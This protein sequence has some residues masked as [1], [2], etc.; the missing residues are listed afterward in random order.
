MSKIKIEKIT[1]EKR[2]ELGIPDAPKNTG[3]WS[4][5]ECEPSS[6]DWQYSDEEVAYVYE[7]KVKVETDEGEIEINKGDLVTFPRGLSCKW[8]VIEKIRKVYCFQ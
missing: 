5:W 3:E 7:G 4:V 1:E 8:N 6:F 2:K